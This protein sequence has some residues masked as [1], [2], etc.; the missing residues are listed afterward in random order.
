MFIFVPIA[1]EL[2]I[3]PATAQIKPIQSNAVFECSLSDYNVKSGLLEDIYWKGPDGSRI[4]Q[5]S[6][7]LVQRLNNIFICYCC[8]KK[9]I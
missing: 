1:Y 9:Y 3:T 6:E 4:Q 5:N 8:T 2:H 7:R